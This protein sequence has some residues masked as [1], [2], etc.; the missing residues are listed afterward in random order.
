MS[1]R[2]RFWLWWS[3]ATALLL[4][5]VVGVLQLNGNTWHFWPLVLLVVFVTSVLALVNLATVTEGSDWSV[6]S[7]QALAPPGQDSRLAMYTRAIIDHLD[8]RTPDSTLRDR[9]AALA[10]RR[11][12]QRHALHLQD[13]A[14][15]NL[16]GVEV[17]SILTGSP[18][19]LTRDEIDRC[20]RRIEEL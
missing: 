15:A 2:S 16:L 20:V 8:A 5:A 4:G 13:A 14:A 9:L 1:A 7:V 17:S 3:V 10:D 6:G 18:R 12:R 19:R 11:L